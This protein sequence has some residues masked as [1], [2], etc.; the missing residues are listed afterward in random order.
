MSPVFFLRASP[1]YVSQRTDRS[2]GEGDTGVRPAHPSVR[3]T[4][5]KPDVASG[6]KHHGL[7][8]ASA[9]APQGRLPWP[10]PGTLSRPFQIPMIHAQDPASG[11]HK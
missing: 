4:D 9:A 8:G 3:V 11:K 2:V 6:R 1:A 5:P 7:S 10:S